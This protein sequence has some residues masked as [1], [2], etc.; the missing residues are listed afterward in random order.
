MNRS[1]LSTDELIQAAFERRA[2]RGDAGGLR[3][4]IVSR[5]AGTPQRTVWRGR[6]PAF[7]ATP[8]LRPARV[9]LLNVMA[10]LCAA[11]GFA[12]VGQHTRV[13]LHS[14]SWGGVASMPH[15]GGGFTATVLRDGKVLVAGGSSTPQ[16]ATESGIV[17]LCELYDPST[18]AWTPTDGMTD[19]RYSFSAVR[20]P[21]G[22]VL[23]AGGWSQAN[24]AFLHSAEIYD[25][26]TGSWTSVGDMNEARAGFT[27]TLL[28]DGMVLVVGGSQNSTEGLALN[29]SA[30]LY[31]PNSRSWTATG[32][33]LA[34][35]DGF[36]ATL[37]ASGK[38]L[39]AGGTTSPGELATAT[40]ELYD[41]TT[42]SWTSTG[43]MVEARAAAVA[44]LLPDGEVLVAG[45]QR[46]FGIH[47][48]ALASA[49]LYDPTA[50]SWTTTGSMEGPDAYMTSTLLPDRRVLVT[51]GFENDV[52]G[53]GPELY[54]PMGRSW[55]LAGTGWTRRTMPTTTLML[56][57]KVLIAGGYFVGTAWGTSEIF[58]PAGGT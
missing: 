1:A 10:L 20:L 54:D 15:A 45:G 8:T 3:E 11:I 42:R 53:V 13:P 9:A 26:S 2:R 29:A 44:T 41:P 14:G 35:R 49:E 12:L 7:L 4:S 39:V 48:D 37:L 27:A 56:D 57:G 24:T 32:N 5:T 23:V 58:D 46:G 38:V 31:D 36:T 51:G 21:D 17:A 50:G 33:L 28:P 52:F 25:P 19:A 6:L 16:G 43:A 30:E 18:G 40:A 34:P 47:N 22:T 55:T